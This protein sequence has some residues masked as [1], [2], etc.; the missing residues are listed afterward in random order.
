MDETAVL[1]R[2][3]G[4]IGQVEAKT[5]QLVGEAKK[6]FEQGKAAQEDVAEL[7]AYEVVLNEAI[8]VLNS[9]ADQRQTE[10]QEKIETLVTHGLKTIFGEEM[11][12]HLVPGMRGKLATMDFVVRHRTPEGEEVDTSVMDARGGGV[13]AVVGF[14]IRLV[15]LLL[16]PTKRHVLFLDE[17][18]AQ[19]SADYEPRLSEFIAE[20][21]EKT[22]VQVLLVTH[23]T[24]YEDSADTSYRF[25]LREGA[26]EVVRQ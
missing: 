10:L 22:D 7:E 16:Q 25:Q 21:V 1:D 24:A 4:A 18:F 3:G 11:S 8:G 17:T 19:L 26:T 15:L 5:H 14:L 2:L 6:V 23:S 9:Y 12:F 20:L 13:A